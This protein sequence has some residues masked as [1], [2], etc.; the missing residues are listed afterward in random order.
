MSTQTATA[1]HPIDSPFSAASTADEVMA[2]VDLSGRT[3]VVTGGYSGLGLETVRALAAAGARVIVPARRPESARE[4]LAGLPGA[5]CEIVP[6]DLTDLADVR[7]AAARIREA[8]DRI[9]FL[10]AVA[11]VMATSERRVGP[12]W[13]YQ[14]AANH[15]GHFALVSE[16]YPLLRAA[17]GARV[18]VYSS[19]GHA[20][21]DFR[22]H[23]PHFRTGYD[24][25]EA[26]GQAKTANVLFAV[27]LDAIGRDD[28]VRA[29]ALH[30]GSIITGLQR[31]L[32]Q[33]EL[34]DLGWVDERGTVIGAGFKT[35]SQGAATGLWAATSP[36]LADR[37]GLYLEDCE[38]A[39]VTYDDRPM[40]EGRVR[41]YAV[42]PASAARLWEL[43]VA[44]TGAGP[45]G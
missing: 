30:P 17:H 13:E 31:E 14:L 2:G 32:T 11:G 3:A 15:L 21:T 28:G 43:S 18:V 41:G 45:I 22:W 19:A 5:S 10:M 8:T 29:F 20:I 33:P 7:S 27:H 4:A 36:L 1:Q 44:A 26:Y 37:G 39:R 9:D 23:D 24:R 35:P 16:L 25:W 40:D 38:V 34:I 12:G 6:M 42:D